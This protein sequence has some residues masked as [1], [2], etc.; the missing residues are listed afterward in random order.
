MRRPKGPLNEDV[1]AQVLKTYAE[2]I[3][4]T[5]HTRLAQTILVST[6]REALENA[7]SPER[8]IIQRLV[9]WQHQLGGFDAQVWRDAEAYLRGGQQ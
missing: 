7:T 8:Q 4:P 1:I 2:N 5:I 6:F 3:N 9:E